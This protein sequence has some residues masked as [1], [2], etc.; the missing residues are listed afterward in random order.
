[1]AAAAERPAALRDVLAAELRFALA[2]ADDEE[3]ITRE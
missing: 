3:A 1:M 2:V